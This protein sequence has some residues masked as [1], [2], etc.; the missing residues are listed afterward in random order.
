MSKDKHTETKVQLPPDLRARLD[1][2]RAESEVFVTQ[3]KEDLG[4]PKP[5][6]R[7]LF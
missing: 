2:M 3:L 7:E 4:I 1:R 6:P 5:K